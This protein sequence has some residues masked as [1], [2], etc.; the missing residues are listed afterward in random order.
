MS[1]QT[2]STSSATKNERSQNYISCRLSYDCLMSSTKSFVNN[3]NNLSQEERLEFKSLNTYVKQLEK[4][5]GTLRN[6]GQVKS[7]PIKR[8]TKSVSSSQETTSAAPVPVAEVVETVTKGKRSGKT[9][10]LSTNKETSP[11]A[12]AVADAVA[13]SVAV[14]SA[15][16][17]APAKGKKTGK[18]A[19]TVTETPKKSAP[20]KAA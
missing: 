10:A 2:V 9:K 5:M 20:K 6:G 18:P 19:T 13:V 8:V 7:V 3:F 17:P 15:P 1:E 14:A 12:Q 11:T 16:S 4:C